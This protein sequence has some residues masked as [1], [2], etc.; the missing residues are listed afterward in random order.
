MIRRS[1]L[2][3]IFIIASCGVP[4]ER[5]AQPIVLSD[6]V[7]EV[8]PPTTSPTMPMEPGGEETQAVVIYLI[9]GQGL[10]GRARSTYPDFAI[11]D[12]LD[13]LAAGPIASDFLDDLSTGVDPSE[14]PVESTEIRDGLAYLG[15]SNAFLQD[16]GVNQ[17]L[18]LGQ[19]VITLM[20]NLPINGVQFTSNGQPIAVPNA[21]GRPVTEPL[22]RRDYASLLSS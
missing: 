18:V 9:R 6:I 5:T 2:A 8:A 21:E 20:S 4:S 17:T 15:L 13:L 10:V 1:S 22:R 12:L 16:S 14:P 11:Q 19:I 3:L 7:L